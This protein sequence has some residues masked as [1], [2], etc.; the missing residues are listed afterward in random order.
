[1]I[2]PNDLLSELKK[3]NI[4]IDKD[5]ILD[6][7]S[8]L[9]NEESAGFF[10]MGC[11]P[12]EEFSDSN[13]TPSIQ[14]IG[15]EIS[16]IYDTDLSVLSISPTRKGNIREPRQL[17]QFMARLLTDMSVVEIGS[18]FGGKNHSTV[19]H[20]TSV[21][22]NEFETSRTIN[23]NIHRLCNHFHVPIA[24]VYDFIEEFRNNKRQY[25]S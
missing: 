13:I 20:S 5:C 14:E 24:R 23:E 19:N 9:Q 10:I 25:A 6:P 4:F 1:M 12:F 22:A 16:K 15:E 2:K 17:A 11:Q 7:V 18:Y 8:L 3:Q 21:I